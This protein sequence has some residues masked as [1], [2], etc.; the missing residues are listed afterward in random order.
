MLRAVFLTGLLLAPLAAAASPVAFDNSWKEQGFFRFFSSN[1]YTLQGDRMGIVS[2][3]T[4]SIIWRPLDS[5]LG[6]ASEASWRWQVTQGV[7]P[8]DL[9]KK[10]GDD[11]NIAL[12]FVFV[13]AETAKTLNRNSARRLLRNESTRAL[14]YVWGG[15][16]KRGT[17]LG[18]PYSN[19]LRTKILRGVE[20]GTFNETVDL[21]SDFRRAFGEEPGVLVGLAI[22]ADSDDTDGV[23]QAQIGRMVIE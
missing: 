23:I 6:D 5:D 13:D 3:G 15:E 10:G 20:T 12:Y 4:V 19:A 18:S 16:H 11:R 14:V 22:T 8:T 9:T 1:D 21:K 2:D 7:I 17:I